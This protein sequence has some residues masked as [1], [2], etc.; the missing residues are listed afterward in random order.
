VREN[1]F[2]KWLERQGFNNT[3]INSRI[4]SCLRICEAEDDLDAL[5][6]KG[7]F[8][9]LLSRLSYSTDDERSSAKPKHNVQISGNIRTGSA[10]LKQSASLYQKFLQDHTLEGKLSTKS[11]AVALEFSSASDLKMTTPT[12]PEPID[13]ISILLEYYNICKDSFYAF[14]VENTIFPSQDYAKDQWNQ[15][16]ENLLTNQKLAIRGYGRLGINTE[17][18]L[19]LYRH[20]FGN[21]KIFKDPTNNAAPTKIIEKAT[22]YKK[23]PKKNRNILNF[24]VA[25]IFGCTKNPLLFNSVWNICYKPTIIDPLSGH[26]ANGDWPKEYQDIFHKY[27]YRRFKELIDDYNAFIEEH[28]V[29]ERIESYI[30]D[31]MST[32]YEDKLIK[33]FS[34]NALSEWAPIPILV[35]E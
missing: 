35:V 3:T 4:S 15:I 33:S 26:E 8:G 34:G 10:T 30:S 13:S 21:H 16:K 32:Q 29:P 28:K 1:E 5:Y 27:V 12:N 23:N 17:M 7:L 31:V 11:K 22:G 24:T 9:D 19:D 2:R 20:L 25:H 6:D 18:F 14:G